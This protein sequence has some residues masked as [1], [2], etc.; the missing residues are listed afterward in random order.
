MFAPVPVRCT[1]AVCPCPH[2][3]CGRKIAILSLPESKAVH[4][5]FLVDAE[6]AYLL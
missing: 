5:V 3:E 6:E 2:K 1:E 4:S